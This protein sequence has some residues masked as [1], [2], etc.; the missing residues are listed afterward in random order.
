[1]NM[2]VKFPNKV[3]KNREEELLNQTNEEEEEPTCRISRLIRNLG[4]PYFARR[5]STDPQWKNPGC[6]DRKPDTLSDMGRHGRRADDGGRK[7]VFGYGLVRK[8][9]RRSHD[10]RSAEDEA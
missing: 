9:K 10:S 2:Q 7:R 5:S 4:S 1:M 8:G 6:N 3:S